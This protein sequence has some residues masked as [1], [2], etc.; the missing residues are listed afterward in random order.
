MLQWHSNCGI[1]SDEVGTLK[2]YVDDPQWHDA[3]IVVSWSGMVAFG[4]PKKNDTMLLRLLRC[5]LTPIKRRQ[6]LTPSWKR[7]GA[8]P[9]DEAMTSGGSK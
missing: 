7:R 2:L 3:L 5:S 8:S 4:S 6:A 9:I 1:G